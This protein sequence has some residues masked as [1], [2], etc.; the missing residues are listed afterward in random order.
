MAWQR[1]LG[2]IRWKEPE[3]VLS[4]GYTTIV[5]GF[6]PRHLVSLWEV[7]DASEEDGVREVATDMLKPGDVIIGAQIN[8]AAF[9]AITK[10]YGP[11]WILF[12]K[13]ENTDRIYR[14]EFIETYN[15][16]PLEVLAIQDQ[17]KRL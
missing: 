11:G 1:P 7:A 10:T 6:Q 15:N 2:C 4:L 14:Q 9:D 8:E 12:S 16:D 3:R 17:K 13:S 5:S